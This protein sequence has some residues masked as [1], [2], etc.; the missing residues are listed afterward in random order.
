MKNRIVDDEITLIPYYPNDA[1]ALEWY[2][3]PELCRMVDNRDSVYDRQA[4]DKRD[5]FAGKGKKLR[6]SIC[7]DLF[8]QYAVTENV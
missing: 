5:H 1:V 4:C 7:T 6:K 3:D 8:F 2:Q